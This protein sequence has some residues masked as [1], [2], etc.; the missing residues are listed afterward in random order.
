M[1]QREQGFARRKGED[2]TTSKEVFHS[3]EEMLINS[4]KVFHSNVSPS[5]SFELPSCSASTGNGKVLIV[6]KT[7]VYG[8]S[9]LQTPWLSGWGDGRTWD[10][11]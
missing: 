3:P 10:T 4:W 8:L 11:N 1:E 5:I 7:E 9:R 2:T 6:F